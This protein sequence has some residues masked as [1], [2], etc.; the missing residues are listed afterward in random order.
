MIVV[1][2]YAS[3]ACGSQV[4]PPVLPSWRRWVP[5]G[6]STRHHSLF[7]VTVMAFPPGRSESSRS[8]AI[9]MGVATTS[10]SRTG[11]SDG[12]AKGTAPVKA[13]HSEY[14]TDAS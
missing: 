8:L 1:M 2:C 12:S 10:M 5:A 9:P 6:Q 3:L 11:C 7:S 4:P 14:K 13:E